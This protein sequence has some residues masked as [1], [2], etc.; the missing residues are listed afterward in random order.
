MSTLKQTKFSAIA[1]N[2]RV[3]KEDL[4]VT[5]E[6]AREISVP[7][8]YFPRLNIATTEEQNNYELI[9]RGTGIHWKDI[10]EDISVASLLGLESD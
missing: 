1:K 5:L 6:D 2:V 7:L 10:D 8:I 9:C 4:I 3:T